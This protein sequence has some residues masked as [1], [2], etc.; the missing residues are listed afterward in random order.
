MAPDSKDPPELLRK[1]R[2]AGWVLPVFLLTVYLFIKLQA[3]GY[4][5]QAKHLEQ[6]LNRLRPA[7]SAMVLSEQLKKTQEACAKISDQVRRLDLRNGRL[8]DLL[9]RLPPSIT[10]DHLENRARLNV[11]LHQ[12]F[13]GVSSEAPLQTDLWIE[14]KLLPGI[15]NPERVL[16]RWAKSLQTA[17]VNAQI[18]RLIPS[19]QDADVWLFE[20][21]L[22]G[23]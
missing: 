5:R 15:R 9:S 10:L 7:L 2:R 1:P 19:P 22:G 13:S 4:A 8:L 17:G 16:V 21:R 20:L 18:Q 11:P 3:W 14:G 23:G 6:E 12:I